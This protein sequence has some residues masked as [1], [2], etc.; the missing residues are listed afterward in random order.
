MDK[1][2]LRILFIAILGIL[3]LAS[4]NYIVKLAGSAGLPGGARSDINE[5]MSFLSDSSIDLALNSNKVESKAAYE[6][7]FGNPF[8][9]LNKKASARNPRY[10]F[11]RK[12][13]PVREKLIAKGILYKKKKP[14]AILEDIRGKTHIVAR[15][16]SIGNQQVDDIKDNSIVIKDHRGEYE[17]PVGE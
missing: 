6:G 3:W 13:E 5:S 7:D 9:S 1:K 17:I 15:G 14:L 10:P 8:R 16:D 2:F 4:A 12:T 11:A